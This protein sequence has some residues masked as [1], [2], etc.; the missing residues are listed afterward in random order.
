VSFL[1]VPGATGQGIRYPVN[2][3]WVFVKVP[4]HRAS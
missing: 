2:T 1:N 3:T 4:R